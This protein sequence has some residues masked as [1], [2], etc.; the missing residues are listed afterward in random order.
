MANPPPGRNLPTLTEVVAPTQAQRR[1]AEPLVQAVMREIRPAL[2]AE[3]QRAAQAVL[4][5]HLTTVV[6]ALQTEIERLVQEAIH[7]AQPP[8]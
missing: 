8:G 6:P 1:A 4:Q 2:E 3:L 5:A 7:R